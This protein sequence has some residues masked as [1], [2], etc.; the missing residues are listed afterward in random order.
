M[1]FFISPYI[2]FLRYFGTNTMSA[3]AKMRTHMWNILPC[4]GII[5]ANKQVNGAGKMGRYICG[6]NPRQMSYEPLCL[7]D[8]IAADNPVRA[9]AV[10]VD[11]MDIPSQGFVY[12]QTKETGRK[13]YNPADMSKLYIKRK[14]CRRQLP[15]CFHLVESGRTVPPFPHRQPLA[16][17]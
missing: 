14:L 16:S 17:P 3:C 13:P 10:I 9:I 7:D 5:E 12:S 8:M 11:R 15:L 4:N 6:Q 2:A 1:S